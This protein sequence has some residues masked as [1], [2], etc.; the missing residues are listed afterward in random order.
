MLEVGLV[1]AVSVDSVV[2][3]VLVPVVLASVVLAGA[4]SVGFDDSVG[5]ALVG[6][7]NEEK[8]SNQMIMLSIKVHCPHTPE[9]GRLRFLWRGSSIP[10]ALPASYGSVAV[11]CPVSPDFGS[12]AVCPSPQIILLAA[13]VAEVAALVIDS[14][15]GGS[16][17]RYQRI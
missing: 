10:L 15:L 5:S 7:P 11:P 17:I 8:V 6:S 12:V 13:F 3:V 9:S 1:V 4:V 14:I 16:C 2:F